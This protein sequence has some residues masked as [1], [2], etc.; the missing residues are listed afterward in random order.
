MPV[1]GRLHRSACGAICQRGSSTSVLP[2][3]CRIAGDPSG[4]STRSASRLHSFAA[5]A[6][7]C[8]LC[9]LRKSP[10]AHVLRGASSGTASCTMHDGCMSTPTPCSCSPQAVDT[11]VPQRAAYPQGP[12]RLQHVEDLDRR[13]SWPRIA[14][15]DSEPSTPPPG[16]PRG[17]A[18][19]S[20]A[21]AEQAQGSEDAGAAQ[22]TA[23]PSHGADTLC[24]RTQSRAGQPRHSYH[25]DASF[26]SGALCGPRGGEA[27][28]AE[29]QGEARALAIAAGAKLSAAES[30]AKSEETLPERSLPE[31]VATSG[32]PFEELT[33]RGE[34][35]LP[36]L[37]CSATAEASLPDRTV[38]RE[39]VTESVKARL[40]GRRRRML[41][42]GHVATM[43]D[44]RAK[45]AEWLQELRE[46][47]DKVTAALGRIT[48]LCIIAVGVRPD[49]LLYVVK[50]E[51]MCE[52]V[53]HGV[54]QLPRHGW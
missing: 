44:G 10:T 30:S 7:Q 14:F 6:T 41:R 31:A 20:T 53:R 19:L 47:V 49:S 21:A 50:K 17:S 38:V 1:P 25:G 12:S 9:Q 54:K 46:S 34:V 42:E 28:A 11:A 45:S 37:E 4:A 5:T 27:R 13:A 32:A 23:R 33:A 29:R 39:V 16:A 36:D 51:E 18:V 22:Q 40:S 43:L 24:S 15:H 35:F 8:D 48:G 52:E 26:S 2:G 3:F